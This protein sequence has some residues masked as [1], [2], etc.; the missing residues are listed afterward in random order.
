MSIKEKYVVKSIDKYL[1]KDWLLHKHYAKRMPNIM[2]AF[3]LFDSSNIMQGVCT[4]GMPPCHF[5]YGQGIFNDYSV[6]TY[7]LTRLVINENLEKNIL[8]FFVSATIKMIKKPCCLLSFADPN[9]GHHGYI[10]QATNWLY[11]GLSQ[12]GG[13]DK[14]W[15]LNNREYHAKTITIEWIKS[16]YKTYDD[17]KNMTEN[18][19]N[20]GGTVEENDLRKYRY[21]FL[22]GSKADIIRMKSKLALPILQYPKGQNIRYDSSYKPMVQT[23]LF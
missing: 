9:N 3:G 12:K 20:M 11:T 17:S 23:E 4:Y 2:F 18:W 21:I 19:Q 10:Y 5:N 15:I 14:Q 16:H 22:S 1:T 8:S 13:K 6:D 7:E